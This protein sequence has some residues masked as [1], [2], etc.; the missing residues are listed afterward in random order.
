VQLNAKLVQ[1]FV[2]MS[3]VS[4]KKQLI[5]SLDLEYDESDD[6]WCAIQQNLREGMF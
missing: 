1:N 6:V 5:E 4:E 3:H 2:E